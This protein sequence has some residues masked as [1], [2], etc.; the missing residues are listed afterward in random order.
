MNFIEFKA[1]V[2]QASGRTD[3]ISGQ[4]AMGLP[5]IDLSVYTNEALR[6]LQRRLGDTFLGYATIELEK[7]MRIV[8]TSRFIQVKKVFLGE[9]E[10]HKAPPDL[11]AAVYA[12]KLNCNN[13][14]WTKGSNMVLNGI[15]FSHGLTKG[16]SLTLY[17]D[18]YFDPIKE[19]KDTNFLLE[20]HPFMVVY[21]VLL[22]LERFYKNASGIAELEAA[23][24]DSISDYNAGLIL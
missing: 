22:L 1:L 5:T 7:D 3:L 12:G 17:G 9:R 4:K 19:D 14:M 18:R 10:V 8:P 24:N 2:L 20:S 11:A 23:V 6:I 16:V 15:A 13:L 21:Q